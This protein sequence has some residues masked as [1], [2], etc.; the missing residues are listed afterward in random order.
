MTKLRD[1]GYTEET[2]SLE[3]AVYDYIRN[4]LVPGKYLGDE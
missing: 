2:T 4:Y 3:D 1:L